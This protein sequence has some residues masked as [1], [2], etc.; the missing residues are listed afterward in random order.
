M[1]F[2]G[3]SEY[4]SRMEQTSGRLMLAEHLAGLLK[5][6]TPKE[7]SPV[8]YMV[9]G[10]LLPPFAGEP[11]GMASRLLLKSMERAMKRSGKNG[12]EKQDL[13]DRLAE[14]GDPGLLAEQLDLGHGRHS[15]EILEVYDNLT[16]IAKQ[17]G[18]GSQDE[19]IDRLATLFLEVSCRSS[20]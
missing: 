2:D 13:A 11:M 14:I 12:V 3:F 7:T 9:Q 8:L 16:A 19:K 4:L 1:E 20:R 5:K 10:Q 15:P 18:S 17:T 6:L